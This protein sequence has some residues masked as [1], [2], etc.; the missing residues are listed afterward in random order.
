MFLDDLK[1]NPATRAVS[2]SV[3]CAAN[4]ERVSRS[5]LRGSI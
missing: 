2:P 5:K 4:A 3:Y 1:G